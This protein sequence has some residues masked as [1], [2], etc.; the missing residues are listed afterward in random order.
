[1]N[2]ADSII[3][4]S[5]FGEGMNKILF[6]LLF[7]RP[8]L[9]SLAELSTSS[10]E[11]W[12]APG[13]AHGM[14]ALL[15]VLPPFRTLVHAAQ[16]LHGFGPECTQDLQEGD[17][18]S[19]L[20]IFWKMHPRISQKRNLETFLAASIFEICVYLTVDYL[21][22]GNTLMDINGLIAQKSPANQFCISEIS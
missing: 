15:P 20:G 11:A 7:S 6:L 18:L 5:E 4:A 14:P 19:P 13:R 22:M 16:S 1:M 10:A 17:K 21:K 2:K 3:P 9:I 12:S 8:Y